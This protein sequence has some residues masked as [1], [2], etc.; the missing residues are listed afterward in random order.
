[1][2]IRFKKNCVLI[3]ATT[4]AI[5]LFAGYYMRDIHL[6]ED[7]SIEYI[8]KEP[9]DGEVTTESL[10]PVISI[11]YDFSVPTIPRLPYY[12]YK[13]IVRVDTI[14]NTIYPTL[15]SAKI[16]HAYFKKNYYEFVLFDNNYGKLSLKQTTQYNNLVSTSYTFT[17][18]EKVVTKNVKIKWQPFFSFN[19]STNNTA[20]IGGGAFYKNIGFEYI[21][22]HNFDTGQTLYKNF[23]TFGLKYKW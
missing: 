19:Y 14:D 4:L 9:I 12:V 13:E 3:L 11:D 5:G 17:P 2:K 23:H 7:E 6:F 21:Y 16:A 20:G 1:M 10:K 15:D 8:T 22:N 18:I